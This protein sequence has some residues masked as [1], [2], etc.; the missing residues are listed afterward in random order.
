MVDLI[1]LAAMNNRFLQLIADHVITIKYLS[2]SR[3]ITIHAD[4]GLK[5]WYKNVDGVQILI[6]TSVEEVFAALKYFGHLFK[7]LQIT[8]SEDAHLNV[9]RLQSL[10]NKHCSGAFITLQIRVSS[11]I[12]MDLS[13]PNASEVAFAVKPHLALSIVYPPTETLTE[14]EL[15]SRERTK[16]FLSRMYPV[17]IQPL[18]NFMC[19]HPQL[20]SFQSH[21]PINSTYL[22][23]LNDCLPNL[24]KLSVTLFPQFIYDEQTW[25]INRFRNVEHFSVRADGYQWTRSPILESI[26]FDHLRIFEVVYCQHMQVDFLIGIIVKNT[27]VKSVVFNIELSPQQLS[28]LITS[29]HELTDLAV[30]VDIP[31]TGSSIRE[32]LRD[33]IASGHPLARLTLRSYQSIDKDFCSSIPQGWTCEKRANLIHIFRSS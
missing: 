29:L 19:L 24:E 23:A 2:Q 28:T 25:P 4:N 27:A 5:M 31:S 22:A 20:L 10:V 26:Q 3:E 1:H 21:I 30:Y 9:E 11:V 14:S 18:V 8:I 16:R 7:H 13:F 33:V 15:E 12:D 6:T 17:Q 32:R